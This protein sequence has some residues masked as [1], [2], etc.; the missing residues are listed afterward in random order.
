MGIVGGAEEM[1]GGIVF[2]LTAVDFSQP[3]SG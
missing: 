1:K 2:E 3:R